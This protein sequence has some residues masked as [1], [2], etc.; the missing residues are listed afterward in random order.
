MRLLI[1]FLHPY[2][3]L[4]GKILQ[5]IFAEVGLTL[6]VALFFSVCRVIEREVD[7]HAQKIRFCL[8]WVAMGCH[9]RT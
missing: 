8:P 9:V 7:Q 6:D 2:N 3:Q 4:G 1:G 5:I